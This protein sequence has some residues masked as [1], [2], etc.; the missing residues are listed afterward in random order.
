[1]RLRPWFGACLAFAVVPLATIS[2]AVTPASA[3]L[4]RQVGIGDVRVAEGDSG[5]TIV[6]LTVGLDNKTVAKQPV[7][8][9]VS[10][11][12]ATPNTDYV[13]T[14][15]GVKNGTVTIAAGRI[16]GAVTVTIKGDVVGGEGD[17][18]V[19]VDLISANGATIVR[20]R[21]TVTIVDDDSVSRTPTRARS[22]DPVVPRVAVGT[23][24]LLEGDGGIRHAVV[25]VALSVP[26]PAPITVVF[27]TPGTDF[28]STGDSCHDLLGATVG[29][30]SVRVVFKAGQQSKFARI[31]V[32]GNTDIGEALTD[33]LASAQITAGTATLADPTSN[34]EI[35]EDD[36]FASDPGTAPA[37]GTIRISQPA[38]GS[39]PTFPRDVANTSNGCGYPQSTNASTSAD[40]HYV[41]FSSNANNLAGDDT[42]GYTD[43]FLE[44]TWTGDLQLVS[45]GPDGAPGND[46]SLSESISADG[47]YLTFNSRASNL[48]SGDDNGGGDSF[49]YDRIAR[50]LLR[51]GDIHDGNGGSRSASLSGDGRFVAFSSDPLPGFC[52]TCSGVYVLD[53]TTGSYSYLSQGGM[54]AVSGD[55]S[56]VAF[57]AWDTLGHGQVWVKNLATGV[58]TIDSRNSAGQLADGGIYGIYPTRPAISNDGS[59][60][61]WSGQ[62]CNMGLASR[63]C[64]AATGNYVFETWV[65][66]RTAGTTTLGSVGPDGTPA[67][68]AHDAVSMS[69]D[70]TRVLFDDAT[71]SFS[72]ECVASGG[73]H[74]FER[75]L[76]AGTTQRVDLV[77]GPDGCAADSWSAGAP[78]MSADGS[79]VVYTGFLAE[80]V[81]VTSPEAVYLTRL[82]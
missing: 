36:S 55:G 66:D 44:N 46:A 30:V 49:V 35:L 79:I 80:P 57:L 32:K 59:V 18:T 31:A 50:T 54:P 27:Q 1:M 40:G 15:T 25:P 56:T 63:I 22:F 9:R 21:G 19:F 42:N 64:G 3:A 26:A 13:S 53:Q 47:R 16:E 2:A 12:S 74:V 7:Q 65:R 14:L 10:A 68:D 78:A 8:Y 34:I 58:L 29:P 45:R 67:D 52:A 39:N 73:R 75:D 5:N 20:A 70:G 11:G 23:P 6:K 72:P 71:P 41:V 33:V 77:T 62:H 24:T 38:D 61:A 76:V 37:I 48:V 82:S 69:A 51:L 17:E 43:V 28:S 4:V 81:S 60:V